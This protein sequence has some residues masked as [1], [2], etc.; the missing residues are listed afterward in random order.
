[1]QVGQSLTLAQTFLGLVYL[2]WPI[3][4]SSGH[5]ARAESGE[6][7]VIASALGLNRLSSQLDATDP[8]RFER[9]TVGV[10]RLPLD[11]RTLVRGC[12][13]RRDMGLSSR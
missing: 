1:M 11:L 12:I 2:P 3:L 5:E 10:I 7:L 4:V 13:A 6:L 8:G 9:L